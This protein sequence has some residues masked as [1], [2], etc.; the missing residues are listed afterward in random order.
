MRAGFAPTSYETEVMQT[1]ATAH[2]DNVHSDAH[3]SVLPGSGTVVRPA[4]LC[5]R[6]APVPTVRCTA[7]VTG[8]A[9]RC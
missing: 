5:E 7:A 6:S 4:R 1:P 3:V 9:V 2:V 8:H